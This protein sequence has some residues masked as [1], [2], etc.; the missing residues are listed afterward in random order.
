MR[1]LPKRGAVGYDD[2]AMT[3]N[4]IW[5]LKQVHVFRDL[6]DDFTQRLHAITGSEE[7]A[8]RQVIFTPTEARE[9]VYILKAGEVQIYRYAGDRKVVVD[10]LRAGDVFGDVLDDAAGDPDNYAEALSPTYVCVAGKAEFFATLRAYPEAAL[11]LLAKF[12]SRLSTAEARI[13]DLAGLSV[14][15]RLLNELAREAA[16]VH[17]HRDAAFVP[18]PP[19][20]HQ[21]LAERIG[22]SRET[23]TKSLAILKRLGY[24]RERPDGAAELDWAK[25]QS[26]G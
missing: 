15:M 4:K 13:R 2:R 19:L 26:I 7:F 8:A 14:A 20:T 6:P 3:R 24:L 22:A 18:L 12:G 17:P 16:A 1:D 10:T 25:A 21:Q 5:Y 11:R 9:K 23:V